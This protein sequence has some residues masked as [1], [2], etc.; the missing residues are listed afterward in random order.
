MHN[1]PLNSSLCEEFLVLMFMLRWL[2]LHL[3][4]R[5]MFDLGGLMVFTTRLNILC[6]F[7][8]WPTFQGH[9]G[10]HVKKVVQTWQ[11]DDVQSISFERIDW[12]LQVQCGNVLDQYLGQV[13]CWLKSGPRWPTGGHF[14]SE[15]KIA[16]QC[17][18]G[19]T[20]TENIQCTLCWNVTYFLCM[21]FISK[22]HLLPLHVLYDEMSL[23]SS[24]CTLC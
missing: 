3:P 12:H 10:Q 23:T 21:Y 6:K 14:V 22:C 8:I 7:L 4:G 24:A 5:P 16:K 17:V 13:R 15:S 2:G 9:S 20:N 11:F 1:S 19:W 18:L